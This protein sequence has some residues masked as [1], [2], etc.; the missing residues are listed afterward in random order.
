MPFFDVEFAD[1]IVFIARTAEHI[2]SLLHNVQQEAAICI[3][4]E[5]ISYN[6]DAVLYSSN[7]NRMPQVSWMVHVEGLN[8]Q[9]GKPGPADGKWQ[10]H[11]NFLTPQQ[12]VEGW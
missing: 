3:K 8:H 11:E 6:S 2:Q 10:R 1:D 5:N 4:S 9:S 7:G 12:G